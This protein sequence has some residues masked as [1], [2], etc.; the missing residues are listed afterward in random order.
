MR[1]GHGKE[2]SENKTLTPSPGL[3]RF[4]RVFTSLH[5]A[6]QVSTGSPVETRG[7]YIRTPLRFVLMYVVVKYVTDLYG[8]PFGI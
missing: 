2:L 8:N 3:I 1:A 5:G 7:S 4:L 6:P